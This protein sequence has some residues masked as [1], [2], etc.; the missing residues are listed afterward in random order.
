MRVEGD[1]DLLKLLLREEDAGIRTDD[2]GLP[3]V[4]TFAPHPFRQQP[5]QLQVPRG[6]GQDFRNGHSAPVIGQSYCQS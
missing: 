1:Q 5:L 2:L 6:Q 4:T 3:I